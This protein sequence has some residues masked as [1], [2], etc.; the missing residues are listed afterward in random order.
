MSARPKAVVPKAER[1]HMPGYGIAEKSKGLLPWK[2][3]KDRLT[4]SRQYWLATTRPGGAPHVMPIW[5]LWLEDGFYFSTGR[6]S[7]KA[8]NLAKEP[9]C[10]VCSDDSEEAVIVEGRVEIIR[11]KARLQ[12]VYTA[13]KKKYKFDVSTMGEPFYKVVPAVAFGMFEKKFTQTATRWTFAAGK[14]FRQKAS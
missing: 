3:A 2:W 5:G 6:T 13:Y 11:E 14:P 8:Q 12:P 4:K 7:R 9:R 10:V 1:P